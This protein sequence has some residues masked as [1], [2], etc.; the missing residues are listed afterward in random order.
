MKKKVVIAEHIH[1]SGIKVLEESDL[2]E[3]IYY[4]DK[5]IP[6]DEYYE[7]LKDTSAV[8]VRIKDFSRKM[9]ESAPDLRIISKHGVGYDNIDVAAATQKKIPVTITPEANADSVADHTLSLMLALSR[10]LLKADTDLKTGQF[11]R[12]E[13]YTG[14]ELGE[15]TLGIIGLGRVGSRVAKRCALGFGMRTIAYDPF[16][17]IETAQQRH[18]ELIPELDPLLETSDYVTIHTPLTELTQ[19][20]IGQKELQKMKPYAFI[21]NTARGGIIDE[22]A[23]YEALTQRWI[24]GAGL[25]VFVTE[26]AVPEENQILSLDNVL[27]TPH[28]AGGAEEAAIKMATHAAEEIIRV[29]N[30]QRPKNPINP[31]IYV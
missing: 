24:R 5:P 10:N 12:R 13:H 9:I 6:E 11:S 16:I 27:V 18:A 30:G 23:L 29:F 21:F 26:P 8:L 25:D 15:K 28:I 20:M 31:E 1:E 3:T 17:S 19:N 22:T 2:F 14:L 4:D 7:V